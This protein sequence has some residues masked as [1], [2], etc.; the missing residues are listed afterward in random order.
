MFNRTSSPSFARHVLL[1]AG[2]VLWFSA[3]HR[4]PAPPPPTPIIAPAPSSSFDRDGWLADYAALKHYLGTRYANLE[5]NVS[6]RRLDVAGL[7][8]QT[9]EALRSAKSDRD[10]LRAV[11]T[12]LAAFKDPHLRWESSAAFAQRVGYSLKLFSDGTATIVHSIDTEGCALQQGANVVRINGRTPDEWIHELAPLSDEIDP[13]REANQALG[14][15]VRSPFAP[16]GGLDV[17]AQQGAEE[18][19]CHLDPIEATPMAEKPRLTLDMPGPIA[20]AAMGFQPD[21]APLEIAARDVSSLQ[22]LDKSEPFPVAR[23]TR[24]DGKRVAVLRIP[25]FDDFRYPEICVRAWD[26]N[27]TRVATPCDERC[28]VRFHDAVVADLL[29]ELGE[30]LGKIRS[31]RADALLVDLT[32]NGGGT[33]WVQDVALM[34]TNGPLECPAVA[35][36]RDETR[37]R[38][39]EELVAATQSCRLLKVEPAKLAA[40]DDAVACD[41]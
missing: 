25:L 3:C 18:I 35:H 20:C 6:T 23:I 37:R 5:W 32:G 4:T 31:A 13:I 39:L 19:R 14:F 11:A 30:R 28:Q 16:P 38:R 27:R 41:K 2:L 8:Q 36:V 9:L 10:A 7:N 12:F 15:L 17:E 34:L 1:G 40:V 26:K 24:K 21:S 33:D 29:Q 22:W